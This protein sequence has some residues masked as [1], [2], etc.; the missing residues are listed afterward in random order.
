MGTP[1]AVKV[2]RV[3]LVRLGSV[4]HAFDQSQRFVEALVSQCRRRSI[5]TRPPVNG[6]IAPPGHYILTL[7][8]DTGVPSTSAIIL[9][10]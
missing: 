7:L 8:D 9:I 10:H 5:G 3:T 6:A 4:T 1:D 2:V